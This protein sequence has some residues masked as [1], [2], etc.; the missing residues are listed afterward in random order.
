LKEAVNFY[1]YKIDILYG[2][3]FERGSHIFTDLVHKYYNIKQQA[4]SLGE[5]SKYITAK[6]IMN[7]LFGRFGMKPI[8]NIVKIV[9]KDESDKIH[10]HHNVMENIILNDQLEYIKYSTQV[11]DLFYELHGLNDYEEIIN[12][13]DISQ[14]TFETSLPIAI[15]TTAY[16]RMYMN[17]FI[18]KYNVFNTDTDSLAIDTPLPEELIGDKLGQFKLEMLANEAYFIS[19]KLYYLKNDMK[20]IIKARTLGGHSLIKQDFI[21][22]SYGLSIIKNRP[23]FISSIKDLSVSLTNTILEL[24]PIITKRYPIYST[25]TGQILKTRPLYVNNGIIEKVNINIKTNII[26]Y[27]GEN[28]IITSSIN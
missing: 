13:L 8:K 12:Q 3:K 4:K 11:N 2:Y 27:K 15:A 5:Y 28:L 18:Q 19:P 9:G 16:A 6:L 10:L 7:S 1:G 23:T 21:D 20:E 24:N 25:V 17:Q 14:T 26:P 22:M